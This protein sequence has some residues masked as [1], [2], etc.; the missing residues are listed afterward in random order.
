MNLILMGLPGA[1]KGTQAEKI[2]EKYNIPHI[3][4][5]DM[6]RLAIKE[7]TD[8]GKKAKEYMDQGELVPDEVTIGIVR[9]RLGKDDCKNGFLLDGFPR[10]IAQA[11]ALQDLL[12][13]MDQSI[14]Y[15][16]H[17]DVPEEKLVERLT[18]RRICPTCG[19]TYHV[20]YNPPKEDGVCDKDGSQLIQRDDDKA[21][22]VKTRLS[23]NME[24]TKPL[25]DFYEDRG[26]L[27]TVNGDKDIDEVFQDIQSKIEK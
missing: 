10:T 8:L 5:G 4:T 26:Y 23:V 19:A 16:L 14:D 17:V 9:E 3:S 1:G 25:L 12:Q 22:T 24:Q 21:D 11:E 15:V 2:N 13:D 6:F 27:V 18:G 20:V 7:G